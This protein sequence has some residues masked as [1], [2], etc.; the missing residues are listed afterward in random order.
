MTIVGWDASPDEIKGVRDGVIDA[1][2]VQ[3]PFRMGFDG[4]NAVVEQVR[5]GVEPQDTD[6]GVTIVT[7][8]PKRSSTSS[9]ARVI[10]SVRSTGW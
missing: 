6:T 4:V 8:W 2:I 7:G 1:L 10:C 5:E 3:N 9:T